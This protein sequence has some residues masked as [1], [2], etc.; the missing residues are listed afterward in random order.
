MNGHV[1]Q[2]TAER[3]NN[4]QFER[5]LEAL[6]AYAFKNLD[7]AND[8]MPILRNLKDEEIPEP[9]DISDEDAKSKLKQ[10]V[11][12]KNVDKYVERVAKL[13]QNVATMY[14]VAWGQCSKQMQ[15]RVQAFS[16]VEA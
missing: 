11:W 5:T 9:A 3:K 10:R 16:T 13:T 2:T 7:N 4:Q 1:F 14:S 15:S 8:I 6:Q 12:E